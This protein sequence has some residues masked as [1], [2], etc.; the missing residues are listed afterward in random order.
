[1]FSYVGEAFPI[2]KAAEGKVDTT[3]P[4]AMVKRAARRVWSLFILSAVDALLI[5][6][7]ANAI[8]LVRRERVMTAE[9]F[10]M[11]DMIKQ[12]C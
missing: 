7:G 1:M 6:A 3:A 5:G 2:A 8:A 10:M 12:L 11:M 9:N 4:V